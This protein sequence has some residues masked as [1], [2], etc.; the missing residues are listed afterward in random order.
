MSKNWKIRP[1]LWSAL[2]FFL[3]A[4]V[5]VGGVAFYAMNYLAIGSTNVGKFEKLWSLATIQ[6]LQATFD[7]KYYIVSKDENALKSFYKYKDIRNDMMLRAREIAPDLEDD[8]LVSRTYETALAMN[9]VELAA[10]KMAES[11]NTEGAKSMLMDSRYANLA[12]KKN[13]LKEQARTEIYNALMKAVNRAYR[14]LVIGLVGLVASLGF[15]AY[16]WRRLGII[17]KTQ[18]E[19]LIV[20]RD[21]L[22]NHATHLEERIELR[23]RDLEAA[24]EAAE[25]AD[26][27]KSTFL[28]QMSHEIRTPMN[29]ILGM[30][31]ALSKT[32]LDEK[33]KHF[34]HVISE[35]GDILLNLLNDALDLAKIEAG[36]LE[37]ENIVFNL[38][39]LVKSSEAIFAIRAYE[40]GIN[41][42]IELN[43]APNIWC[44]GDPTRLKQILYNLISNGIKFTENGSVSVNV[45]AKD[46][47][48]HL[49]LEFAVKDTGIGI[50][51]EAQMRL[52]QKFSQ[53][54]VS[55]TRKFGGTGL[56]LA[57]CK[58]LAQIMGGDI[59]VDSEIGKGSVFTLTVNVEKAQEPAVEDKEALKDEIDSIGELRILA[60][61]DNANNRLVLKMFLEQIGAHVT[62]V[63]NGQEAVD[64][65]KNHDFDIILMD[66]QMPVLSGPEATQQIRSLEFNGKRPR[67]PIIALTANAMTHHV[68]EC[69]AAGMDAHVAKPIKPN[70]LFSAIEDAIDENID[71]VSEEMAAQNLASDA[72]MTLNN[73]SS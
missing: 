25:A 4:S 39:E 71:L 48:G 29:G 11:G 14:M 59:R 9:D 12:I 10:V 41:L 54:D 67:T 23:T 1:L 58:Q 5:A 46:V 18:A 40:K 44:C 34:V 56:G 72:S 3:I 70:L 15:A 30:A 60:A 62:F 8:K 73:Q 61:E 33:Q 63:E 47:N 45:N 37:I 31:A 68:A 43:N 66:V 69:L 38:G 57:I 7:A 55:T 19:E 20:A 51:E 53:A 32:N 49:L 24:K 22:A 64:E 42:N 2:F 65:W 6:D 35:S 21:A 50:S 26:Q 36:K 17:F 28:A 13:F 16:L 52:F 27:A